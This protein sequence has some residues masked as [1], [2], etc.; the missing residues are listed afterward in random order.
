MN[1]SNSFTL[2][3]LTHSEIALRKGIDNTPTEEQ[4]VNLTELAMATRQEQSANRT[5]CAVNRHLRP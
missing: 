4:I 1:L 3:E 2:E 5:N